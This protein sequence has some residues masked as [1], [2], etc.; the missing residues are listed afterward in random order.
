MRRV[1]ATDERSWPTRPAEWKVE[2]LVSSAR[3]TSPTSCHPL[4][5]KWEGVPPPP[6]PPPITTARACSVMAGDCSRA[7]SRPSH[8][9][10]GGRDGAAAAGPV[11]VEELPARPIDPLVGVGAEVV[12]LG[13]EEARRE[14]RAPVPV[15]EREGAGERRDRD[16][17]QRSLGHDPPPG[18]L[19]LADG[20]AEER[21]DE[22]AP[23]AGLPVEGFLDLPEE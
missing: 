21:V 9:V 18:R 12:A 2:P 7:R 6:T 19:T 4:W 16:P 11:R 23:E 20:V 5:G 17:R 14:P 1:S 15:V 10:R 8:A 22:K 13:L 3:S